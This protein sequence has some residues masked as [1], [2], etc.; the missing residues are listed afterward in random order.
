MNTT[1]SADSNAVPPSPDAAPAVK[2]RSKI[3]RAFVWGLITLGFVIVAVEG[4]SYF[5]FKRAHDA[6]QSELDQAE[7]AGNQITRARVTELL[8]NREPDESKEVQVIG[9][10]TERYDIYVFQG[11]IKQRELFIH[12]GVAGVT[13]EPEVIEVLAIRPDEIL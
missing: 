12:Y 5:A 13:D 3:E 11:L 9:S 10:A 7:A 6:V 1:S 8:N 4:T 2:S